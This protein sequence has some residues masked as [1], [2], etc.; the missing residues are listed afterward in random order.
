MDY[1]TATPFSRNNED[2]ADS[3]VNCSPVMNQVQHEWISEPQRPGK[4]GLYQEEFYKKIAVDIVTESVYNYP[5]PFVSEKTI[6]PIAC[7]R[8]FII[9]GSP[10]T[11]KLLHSK[12]FET[13]GDVIDESY[14]AIT[15][16][17]ERWHALES[18]IFNFV[19]KPLD[20]IRNIV[21]SKSQ[22][23]DNN[24]LTLKNLQKLELKQLNDT[25]S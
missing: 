3:T 7:K 14:D 9:I 4:W 13:F 5:Y 11:L 12:G 8:M 25:N 23:L 24:F 10:G 17:V 22:S 19:T 21:K 2:W 18:A 16:P 20:E 15:D 1:I 6:R